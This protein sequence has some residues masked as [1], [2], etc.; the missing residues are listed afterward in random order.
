[1]PPESA[2]TTAI[3]DCADPAERERIRT[4]APRRGHGPW[5]VRDYHLAEIVDQLQALRQAVIASGGGTPA[6]V[7]PYPRPGVGDEVGQADHAGFA[8]D[9]MQRRRQEINEQI[10]AA[11]RAQEQASGG[12]EGG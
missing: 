10:E 9:F 12:T 1:M 4:Q 8:H 6:Q 11:R 3:R 7:K 5:A 2:T